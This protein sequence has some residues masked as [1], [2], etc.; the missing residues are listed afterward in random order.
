[1][2]IDEFGQRDGD[3]RAVPLQESEPVF[4]HVG[5]GGPLLGYRPHRGGVAPCLVRDGGRYPQ[6]GIHLQVDLDGWE[7][8]GGVRPRE[9]HQPP[10]RPDALPRRGFAVEVE[11]RTYVPEMPRGFG[12]RFD[13]VGDAVQQ[14]VVDAVRGDRGQEEPVPDQLRERGVHL[15]GSGTGKGVGGLAGQPVTGDGT[16]GALANP[17]HEGVAAD[18]DLLLGP[19]QHEPPVTGEA[20]VVDNDADAA[21]YVGRSEP[22]AYAPVQPPAVEPYSL[23]AGPA[24]RCLRVRARTRGV[25]ARE[26]A[27]RSGPPAQAQR[28]SGDGERGFG[29]ALGAGILA[30]VEP[31]E[32]VGET[33]AGDLDGLPKQRII[34]SRPVPAADVPTSTTATATTA[35]TAATAATGHARHPYEQRPGRLEQL[36]T[37]H[38]S[39]LTPFRRSREAGGRAGAGGAHPGSSPGV[40]NARQFTCTTRR[41]A[42]RGASGHDPVRARRGRGACREAEPGGVDLVFRDLDVEVQ[43]QVSRVGRVLQKHGTGHKTTSTIGRRAGICTAHGEDLFDPV[44]GPYAA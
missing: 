35:L 11:G 9:L 32:G 19:G 31:G 6:V 21:A 18:G 3:G 5:V 30:G 24:D 1:M 17:L 13:R 44:P 33:A 2:R 43:V 22:V 15:T 25:D 23:V 37:H 14:P 10:P 26:Q 39:P 20:E 4:A 38:T 29:T 12:V 16:R 28:V 27:E 42:A 8:I 7:V 40:L 34:D 41:S 36:V